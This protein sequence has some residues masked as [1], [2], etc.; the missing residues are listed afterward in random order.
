[1]QCNAMQLKDSRDNVLLDN[2]NRLV[3]NVRREQ[4]RRKGGK[5]TFSRLFACVSRPK[6]YRRRSLA[7]VHTV[8]QLTS[9]ARQ[10]NCLTPHDT[11]D[12][13]PPPPENTVPNRRAFSVLTVNVSHGMTL[14]RC[15]LCVRN[16]REPK[17]ISHNT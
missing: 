16:N 6:N 7:V 11:A 10:D 15:V 8:R 1:M 12:T 5:R 3:C 9:F 4:T 13:A 17:K 14:G 2:T